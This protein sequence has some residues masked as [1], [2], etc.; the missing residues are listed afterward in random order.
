MGHNVTQN[1]ILRQNLG[2]ARVIF[3]KL[4]S[5]EIIEDEIH[6]TRPVTQNLRREFP[7][8]S[9]SRAGIRKPSEY[10]L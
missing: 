3:K 7:E 9:G 1:K 2:T 8:S 5:W 4:Y 10:E 6:T